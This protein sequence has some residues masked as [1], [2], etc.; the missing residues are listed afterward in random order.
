MKNHTWASAH[1]SSDILRKPIWNIGV[2]AFNARLIRSGRLLKRVVE[3]VEISRNALPNVQLY[4]G[5]GSQNP[6]NLAARVHPDQSQ[7]PFLEVEATWNCWWGF[8]GS[9]WTE[10][11]LAECKVLHFAGADKPW[12]EN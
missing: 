6:W 7:D 4:A 2:L 11:Q 12:M 5:E 1:L 3:W 8:L 9:F 10:R